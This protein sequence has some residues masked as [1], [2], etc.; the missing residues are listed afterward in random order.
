MRNS[1]RVMTISAMLFCSAS[2][3]AA[4]KEKIWALAGKV[5]SEG[6]GIDLHR[7][8]F[9]DKL[10]LRIGASFFQRGQNFSN[11]GIKYIGTLRVGAVPISLDAYPFKNWFRV[12]GGLMV[13]LNRLEGTGQYQDGFITIGAHSYTPN[14]IGTLQGTVNV[15]RVSPFFGLGFGNPIKKDRRFN[16]YVDVG[17][18]YHGEPSLTLQTTQLGSNFLPNDIQTQEQTFNSSTHR[19]V[20]YPL[21]Q[22]GVTFR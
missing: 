8:I 21:L 22:I 13:N 19:Y 16:I 1:L 6:V 5:G 10:N 14:T 17:F 18:V 9:P 3:L 2:A 12:Q 15:D 20:F 11:S 7:V 4:D